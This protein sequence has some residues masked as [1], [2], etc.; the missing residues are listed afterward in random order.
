MATDRT[1][2]RGPRAAEAPLR[3][4]L[5]QRGRRVTLQREAIMQVLRGCAGHIAADDVY[6]RLREEFPQINRSTV[7]RT[8]HTLE[9]LGLVRH[10]HDETGAPRYHHAEDPPHVHLVCRGC[11]GLTA[12]DE[13][14]VLEQLVASLRDRYGFAADPT[15]FPIAGTCAQ[16]RGRRG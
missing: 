5:R 9:E 16:C 11:G 14:P 10:T 2:G 12:V 4:R 15:H 3:D 13:L 7:Y 6:R 8:L 1:P